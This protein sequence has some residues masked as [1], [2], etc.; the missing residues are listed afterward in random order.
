MSSRWSVFLP[1]ALSSEL[2]LA[3]VPSPFHLSCPSAAFS[4]SFFSSPGS[5]GKETLQAS[6]LPFS[7][8]G[9]RLTKLLT[10]L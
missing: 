7:L 10:C 2:L 5:S 8:Y 9:A 1:L 3:Y 6:Q 4:S